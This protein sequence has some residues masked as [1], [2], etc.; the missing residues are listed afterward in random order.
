MITDARKL[1]H[2]EEIKMIKSKKEGNKNDEFKV[3][4]GEEEYQTYLTYISK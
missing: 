4:K 2:E 3:E 1:S